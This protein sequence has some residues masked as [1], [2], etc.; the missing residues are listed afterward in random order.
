[1]VEAGS[2][3]IGIARSH[4]RSID[5]GLFSHCMEVYLASEAEKRKWR[6]LPRE[7]YPTS[8]MAAWLSDQP[9]LLL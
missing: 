7:K 5:Q 1:M 8:M 2:S 6:T 9:L 4:Y 3:V